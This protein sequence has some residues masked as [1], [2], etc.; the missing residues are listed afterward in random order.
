M[1]FKKPCF[2]TKRLRVFKAHVVFDPSQ[3]HMPRDFFFACRSDVDCP[4]VIVSATVHRMP[5]KSVF[6]DIALC[7]LIETSALHRRKGFATE[8][9]RGIAEHYGVPLEGDPV[10][11][12]GRKF[13]ESL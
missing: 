3:G 5:A 13:M 10:T 9:W 7:E 8:L 12:A 1:N 4:M 11:P 2:V 6:G